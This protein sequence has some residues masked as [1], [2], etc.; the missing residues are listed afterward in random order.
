MLT[1]KRSITSAFRTNNLGSINSDHITGRAYDLVGQNL[2]QYATLVN[3]SGG[4]AEFHGR[5]GG[6]HLHVVPGETPMGDMSMPAIRPISTPSASSN[7]YNY[8]VNVNGANA[9]ANEIA[10]RVIDRIQ[11]LEQN[12]RERR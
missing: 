7:V 6:R 12:R 3:N 2:G 5:G 9:D 8:S 1:G 4:F 11:R 10:T